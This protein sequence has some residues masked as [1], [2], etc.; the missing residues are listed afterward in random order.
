M[1]SAQTLFTEFISQALSAQQH[2]GSMSPSIRLSALNTPC[3]EHLGA[4]S[5]ESEKKKMWVEGYLGP[6]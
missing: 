3:S 4:S 2:L 1:V 6:V 5:Q